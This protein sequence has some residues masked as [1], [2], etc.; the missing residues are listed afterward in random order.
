MSIPNYKQ[1]VEAAQAKYADAWAHA[2]VEGDP[3]RLEFI[4]L[5]AK[6]LHIKDPKVNCNGKR[7]NPN[8]LS[9]DAINILC[10]STDSAGRT[11]DG[12]PCVVVDVIG[13]AGG[14]NPTPAWTV[15]NTLVEGSGAPVN[16]NSIPAPVPVPA[17][18]PPGRDEALNE[19]NWLDAYYMAPEGLQRPEGLSLQGAPDFEGIAAWYLDVYQR[20]R[21]AGKSKEDARAAYVKEI[22]SSAEWR[23]KHPGET[24]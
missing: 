2:H 20:A 17:A 4:K 12:R 5:L 10:L 24:P 1:D 7:S 21:M 23:A 18:Q 14:P 8:E 15:Y 9:A 11:P 3:R 13:G 22:R 16:P 6:D 19:L